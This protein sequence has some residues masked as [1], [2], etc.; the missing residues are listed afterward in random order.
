MRRLG[1]GLV[2]AVMAGLGC[3]TVVCEPPSPDYR[4]VSSYTILALKAVFMSYDQPLLHPSR[5]TSIRVVRSAMP[6]FRKEGK[7]FKQ[8]SVGVNQVPDFA[9]SNSLIH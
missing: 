4:N 3:A 5:V 7:R 1:T 2:H 9:T 6:K 8:F